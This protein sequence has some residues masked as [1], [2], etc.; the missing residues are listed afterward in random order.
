[1]DIAAEHASKDALAADGAAA[2]MLQ[3]VYTSASGPESLVMLRAVG[4]CQIIFSHPEIVVAV[5]ELQ[6]PAQAEGGRY[7]R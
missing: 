1:M 2:T 3:A 4:A 7:P 5:R 6:V